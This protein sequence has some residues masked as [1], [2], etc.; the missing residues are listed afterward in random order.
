MSNT[1]V[2][3][4]SLIK[5]FVG[6]GYAMTGFGPKH[7]HMPNPALQEEVSEFIESHPFV[8]RDQGYID[9]LEM[10]AGGATVN[11]LSLDLGPTIIIFGFT[12][13]T[14]WLNDPAGDALLA[15]GRYFRFA[16]VR[17]QPEH[18]PTSIGLSYAWDTMEGQPRGIYRQ[19]NHIGFP[20]I[21]WTIS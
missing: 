21:W 17:I 12:V 11:W 6:L 1:N 2:E 9:F 13:T 20:P 5:R 16:E 18:I 15:Q 14:E 7:P 10:Y 3:L 19:L 4:Q 8:S